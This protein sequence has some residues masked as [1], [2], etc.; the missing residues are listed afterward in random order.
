MVLESEIEKMKKKIKITHNNGIHMRPAG[1]ISQLAQEYDCEIFF[2]YKGEEY[3][4]KSAILLVL[5]GIQA[6]EEI[7]IKTTGKG[8]KKA[9]EKLTQII[10][11]NFGFKK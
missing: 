7:E 11:N 9:L 4:A 2:I 1:L 6:G 8:A 5:A 3:D 10:E